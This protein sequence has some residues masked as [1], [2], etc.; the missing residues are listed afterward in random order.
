[1]LLSQDENIPA[2]SA[3]E[4]LATLKTVYEE[5]A[6]GMD[7]WALARE[8]ELGRIVHVHAAGNAPGAGSRMARRR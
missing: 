2:S 8:P 6:Q 7:A 5:G 1:M 3:V 4:K